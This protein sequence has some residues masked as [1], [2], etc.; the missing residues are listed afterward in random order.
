M[1][2]IIYWIIFI[3]IFSLFAQ[4]A[5]AIP[6]YRRMFQAKYQYTV[7]CALCH[8]NGGGSRRTPFGRDFGKAGSNLQAFLKIEKYDSD[9][10]KILNFDEIKGKSNPGDERSTIQSLG[11]W[12][13]GAND[14]PIPKTILKKVF[15]T[16][17]GFAGIEGSLNDTQ[18]GQVES[19]L[20]QALSDADKVPTFYF[21]VQ[22]SKRIG[23]A[24]LIQVKTESGNALIAV[25]LSAEGKI[26]NLSL[27]D[28]PKKFPDATPLLK[29]M[30]GK[31][32][33]S[34]LKIGSD[35]SPLPGND[36][37]SNSLASGV[38][39]SLVIMQSVFAKKG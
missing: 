31:D 23:V 11:N 24:Q 33:S 12:L 22:G 32:L 20:G 9:G 19:I 38:K 39:R 17:D 4:P 2:A 1:R 14:I 18:V 34:N 37:V 10:D 36:K 35:L 30:I 27:I 6:A 5:D 26:T 3:L 8:E 29:Q 21:G 16:V 25:A 13:E 15:P 28:P 7:T